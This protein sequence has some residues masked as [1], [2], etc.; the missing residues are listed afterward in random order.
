MAEPAAPVQVLRKATLLLEL[1]ANHAELT[2]AQLAELTGEPKTTVYRLVSSLEALELVERGS[3]RGTYRLGLKLL[4]LGSSVLGRFDERQ[5]AL[6]ALR[7]L[8]DTTEQTVYLCIRDGDRAVCI[9]R[10]D[11]RWVRSMVLQ[12][13]GSL[14]L[15]VGAAPR[16]LLAFEGREFWERYIS[17]RELTVMQSPAPRDP[18]DLLETLSWIRDRGYDVADGDTALGM[19]G[20]AAA[21]FDFSGRIRASISMSG[22]SEAILGEN[23][24]VNV[25]AVM[26]TAAEISAALGHRAP[27]GNGTTSSHLSRLQSVPPH[28]R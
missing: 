24:S 22:P 13:G 11:G 7:R 19:A 2:A 3:S 27:H 28:A 26:E 15:H 6:P 5:A 8:H 20:I 1:L 4:E 21:V 12:I 10:I 18:A 17:E 14:P 16:T 25:N 23:Q 9:D